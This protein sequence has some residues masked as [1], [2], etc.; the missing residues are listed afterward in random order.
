MEDELSRPAALLL[1]S[2]PFTLPDLKFLE[3]PFC[4]LCRRFRR[5]LAHK[6]LEIRLLTFGLN[7][8][9][10]SEPFFGSGHVRQPGER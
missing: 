5:L 1:T 2:I 3:E 9:P 8:K 4:P 7:R 10:I 6:L